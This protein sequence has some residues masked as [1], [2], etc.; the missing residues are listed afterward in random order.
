VKVAEQDLTAHV[1]FTTL[2]RTGEEEGLK[3]VALTR[4]A[5]WLTACGLFEE[6]QAA[7]AATRQGAMALLD[8]EGM[9]EEIRVL[10]QA[11]GIETDGLFEPGVLGQ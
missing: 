3:T 4:Q 6:L 8:G 2:I 11:K 7:D 9:G 5:L 10:V 1:D